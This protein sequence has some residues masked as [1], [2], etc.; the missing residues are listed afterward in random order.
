MMYI[1][2]AVS[3]IRSGKGIRGALIFRSI[4]GVLSVKNT[5]VFAPDLWWCMAAHGSG[6]AAEWRRMAAKWNE[7]WTRMKS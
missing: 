6:I 1:T 5:L 2:D 3:A 4:Q 7:T